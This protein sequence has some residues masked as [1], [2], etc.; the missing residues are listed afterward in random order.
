MYLKWVNSLI[1]LLLYRL[2]FTRGETTVYRFKLG[3]NLAETGPLTTVRGALANTR[4][5][6]WEMVVNLD[7]GGYTKTLHIRKIFR[8]MQKPITY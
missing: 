8:K 6:S 1:K 3:G 5:K 7:L 4:K 2:H